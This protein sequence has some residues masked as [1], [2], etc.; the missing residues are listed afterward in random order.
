MQSESQEEICGDLIAPSFNGWVGMES[1]TAAKKLP[2]QS[3]SAQK[4]GSK[5]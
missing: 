3:F 2:F 5:A 1:A 4:I